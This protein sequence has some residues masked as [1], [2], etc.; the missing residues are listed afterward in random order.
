[1]TTLAVNLYNLSITQYTNF[2]FPVMASFKDIVV[3]SDDL[4]GSG[5]I[6]KHGHD[7]ETDDGDYIISQVSLPVTDFGLDSIKHP[8]FLTFGAELSDDLKVDI[9]VDEDNTYSYFLACGNKTQAMHNHKVPCGRDCRGR[10]HQI[11][12]SNPEGGDFS[13]D[14]INGLFIVNHSNSSD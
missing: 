7:Y 1:M 3:M 12:F 9:Q 8:R 5:Y 13:V 14:S 11:S 4:A 10:Y 2:S 6:Y